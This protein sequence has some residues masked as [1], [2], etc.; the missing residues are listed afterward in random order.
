[1]IVPLSVIGLK[2]F[3]EGRLGVASYPGPSLK[4]RGERAWYTCMRMRRGTPEKCGGNRMLWYTLLLSSI[5]L[6]VMQ[7]PQMITMVMRLVAMETPVYAL[8]VCTRPLLLLLLKAWE[9]G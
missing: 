4:E 3:V 6:Y 9:R 8:A 2:P 7:N 1:M 5:E